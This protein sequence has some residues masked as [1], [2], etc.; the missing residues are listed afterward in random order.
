MTQCWSWTGALRE[1]QS[2]GEVATGGSR[3]DKF[4]RGGVRWWVLVV[5]MRS[6]LLSC[7]WRYSIICLLD[8]ERGRVPV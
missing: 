4:N 5:P 2:S 7:H 8:S 3:C 6:P 1:F